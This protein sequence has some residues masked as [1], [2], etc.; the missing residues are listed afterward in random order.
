M[1]LTKEEKV[2]RWCHKVKIELCLLCKHNPI[3]ITNVCP[4]EVGDVETYPE[5]YHVLVKSC[6]K[7]KMKYEQK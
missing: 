5:G 2:I 6:K 1:D 4:I 7:F 3:I